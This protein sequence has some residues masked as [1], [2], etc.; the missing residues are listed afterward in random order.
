MAATTLRK[1]PHL[2]APRIP[3][4]PGVALVLGLS[5]AFAA[6]ARAEWPPPPPAPEPPPGSTCILIRRGGLG[7]IWDADVGL[8]NG[9][10]AAGAYPYTWTGPSPDEHWS[11][12]RFDLSPVPAGAQVVLATFSTYVSWNDKPSEVRIHRI[13]APWDEL[14]VTWQNFGGTA[15]WDPGVIASFDP[16]GVGHK[17][18]DL[19]ALVQAWH[20]G[21][22]PNHGILMEE[23]PVQLHAYFAGESDTVNLRPSLSVCYV[24]GGPCAGKS[25]GAACDDGN[26]CTVGETCQSGQCTGSPVTCAPLDDCHEAGVC[27]PGTGFC[28]APEKLDGSP[29][30]D[31]DLCTSDDVCISGLCMGGQAVSC[32]DGSAC[33]TDVCDPQQGCV[34]ATVSCDDGDACTADS[35]DPAGGCAHEPIVCDDGDVCTVDTCDPATGCGIAPLSC[36]DGNACTVDGCDAQTGCTHGPLSCND[37][38]LCTT[39]SCDPATGCGTTPVVCPPPDGCHEP[40]SCDEATGR[41]AYAAKP[42]GAA[43]DD[44]DACT[45]T[46]TCQAGTCSGGNPVVCPAPDACHEPSTCN[47]ATGTCDLVA[48]PDGTSCTDGN[49][50]TQ[51]DTCLSGAC[52][53]GTPVICPPPDACHDAGTCDPSTG[54]CDNPA[55]PNG[56][57]C[58]DGNACTTSDTCQSGACT[59]GT[60]VTCAAPD[61]CHDAGTCDPSTGV[62][63]N[64]AKPDGAA[65][66]DGTACTA[67]DTCQSG[68]CQ[69]GPALDCNDG[70]PCTDDACDAATGCAHLANTAPCDDGD[71]CTTGDQCAAG[72]CTPA[73]YLSCD[74]GNDCTADTCDPVTA[75]ASVPVAD[76]TSCGV[77]V[78]Q[79]GACDTQYC[80]NECCS[81]QG[82]PG[83]SDPSVQACVCDADPSCCD[84]EWTAACGA[85][86]ASLGC[87]NCTDPCDDAVL[88][89]VDS[90]DPQTGCSH[91]GDPTCGG[92]CDA[93]HA[94][95]DNDPANGCESALDTVA[96]CGACGNACPQ[97]NGGAVCDEGQCGIATCEVGWGNCD[98]SLAN[99]CE[100][101]L[102]TDPLNCGICG[103]SC[104][105]AGGTGICNQGTCV[106]Q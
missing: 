90:C 22:L 1:T 51:V 50:C 47:A 37:G 64:P 19:T 21:A 35:C 17:T 83:C 52:V 84:V 70:N 36:D 92:T 103:R 6:E 65:C 89:T 34:N 16:S 102:L 46:D 79:S 45:Q 87:G 9:T 40:A 28:T 81:A 69:S 53:A 93:L 104:A 12:Y 61:Q 85:L 31:A 60:P 59:S 97:A 10:W 78:C 41:C 66:D 101:N 7:Q 55:K 32:F 75:C 95:C 3:H 62:C 94:D 39:D 29:C 44:G 58:D 96:N 82:G 4:A 14:T 5:L 98:C 80:A 86:V 48:K 23:D 15:S 68:A 42:D 88:C 73:G 99:G 77:G 72:Q 105:T 26:A 74:D 18:T 57:A 100:A 24:A 91:D 54:V 76:N 43:C 11:L 56:A 33:T 13:T 106:V 2:R 71:A 20:A 38:N 25:D 8:G 67:G 30:D 63:D 49:A 27:D